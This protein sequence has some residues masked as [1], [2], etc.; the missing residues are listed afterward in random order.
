MQQKLWLED[1]SVGQEFLSGT[2]KLTAD[3][4]KEFAGRYDPQPFHTDEAAARNT[5]F[6]GLAADGPH[7]LT[8]DLAPAAEVGQRLGRRA[9]FAG[10]RN[11]PLRV[12]LRP[13]RD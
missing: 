6:G 5:M 8:L 9:R 13:P 2:H 3:E 11:E 7:R 4:I 10:R 1:L 12:R